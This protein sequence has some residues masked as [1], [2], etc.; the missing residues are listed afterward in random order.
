MRRCQQM[1]S[2]SD[3]I[4]YRGELYLRLGRIN[5][6]PRQVGFILFQPCLVSALSNLSNR[7][8]VLCQARPS[9]LGDTQV[10]ARL[11]NISNLHIFFCRT[12]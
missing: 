12:T 6:S 3:H 5:V 10:I 1:F 8:G 9:Q 11:R 7:A 2:T 4:G